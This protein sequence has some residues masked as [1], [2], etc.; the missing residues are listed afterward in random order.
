VAEPGAGTFEKLMTLSKQNHTFRVAAEATHLA[1]HVFDRE[2][3]DVVELFGTL[4]EPVDGNPPQQLE[5]WVS[6]GDVHH[7]QPGHEA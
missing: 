3:L 2:H 1:V 6:F 7:L 4:P 5:Q